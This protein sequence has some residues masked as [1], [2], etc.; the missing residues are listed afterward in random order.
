VMLAVNSSRRSDRGRSPSS[1]PVGGV[2]TLITRVGSRWRAARTYDPRRYRYPPLFQGIGTGRPER[3]TL[4]L[5]LERGSA[6][7]STPS[8]PS[9]W[10]VRR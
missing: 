1:A 5:G 10:S 4:V 7:G 2:L 9:P 8:R 6:V 3:T